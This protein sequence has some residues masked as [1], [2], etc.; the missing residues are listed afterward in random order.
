MFAFVVLRTIQLLLGEL[1][2]RVDR[3]SLTSYE[4]LV[5]LMWLR[6]V[7]QLLMLSST[8]H[9]PLRNFEW[10]LRSRLHTS[11]KVQLYGELSQP[12]TLPTVSAQQITSP[13]W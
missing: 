12:G 4:L 5:S 10:A 8:T 1:L 13:L 11:W 7:V 2:Q 3:G 6:L 9:E